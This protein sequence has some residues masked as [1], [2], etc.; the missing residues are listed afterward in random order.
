MHAA[1]DFCNKPENLST[2]DLVLQNWPHSHTT[3]SSLRKNAGG[4]QNKERRG[5]K[6]RDESKMMTVTIHC[7]LWLML[8]QL[9]LLF[10][11]HHVLTGLVTPSWLACT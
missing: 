5:G 8:L 7:Y 2:T 10:K 1:E 4:D 6:R 11:C 3:H 9:H